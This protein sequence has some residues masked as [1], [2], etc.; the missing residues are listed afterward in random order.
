[1]KLGYAVYMDKEY[2][3]TA[4]LYEG[5]PPV[6]S[7]TPINTG[8]AG[9]APTQGKVAF[10]PVPEITLRDRSVCL[11][12]AKDLVVA[13]IIEPEQLYAAAEKMLGWLAKSS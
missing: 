13:K 8:T 11:S 9:N 2:I 1:M 3:A 4:E 7:R 5:N 6:T 10:P 12:Y